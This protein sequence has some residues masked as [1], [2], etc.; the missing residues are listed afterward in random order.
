MTG[1]LLWGSFLLGGEA[2]NITGTRERPRD[3]TSYSS[4]R[5]LGEGSG[6]VVSSFICPPGDRACTSEQYAS[7]VIVQPAFD[8]EADINTVNLFTEFDQTFGWFNMRGGV[9]FDF[10]DYAKNANFAPRLVGTVSP[11]AWFSVS[12]GYNRYYSGPNISYAVRDAQPRAITNL[13][14]ET[15][16]T[17]HDAAGNVSTKF[18]VN[19]NPGFSYDAS[20]L[21]TP[22]ADEYTG[23]IRIKEPL[24]G[25]HFRIRYL[26]RYS[27]D[28][29]SRENC[30]GSTS[31]LCNVLTN[32]GE[33]FYRSWTGEYTTVWRNIDTPFLSSV[34]LTG[35]IVWSEQTA[36]RGTIFDGDGSEI[37]ILYKEQKYTEETFT[38]VTGNLDIPIRVGAVLSTSWFNGM[39][40]L[41][42]NASFNFAYEGVYNTGAP[43]VEIDGLDYLVYDDRTFKDTLTLDLAGQLN[44]TENAAVVFQVDN[45]TDSIGN[46]VASNQNPWV[47]GRSFWLGTKIRM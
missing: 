11:F 17:A 5:T 16:S 27:E 31:T 26:E 42:L 47:H 33:R 22:Y 6:P 25:G 23:A 41:D 46:S 1:N 2:K 14:G 36:N 21:D 24:L 18:R 38:A 44:V 37:Y 3:F 32:N 9:R 29:Y 43:P 35:S 15:A 45:L 10:D 7:T 4:F 12:G 40:T 13:R 20:D 8:I 39:L 28:Q 34:G 19:N 30:P